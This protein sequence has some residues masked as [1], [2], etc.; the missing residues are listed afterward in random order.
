MSRAF[1]DTAC[2]GISR[3]PEYH[4]YLMQPSDQW[5]AIVASDGIWA[6]RAIGGAV[7]MRRPSFSAVRAHGNAL[8]VRVSWGVEGRQSEEF[9]EGEDCCN[10]TSKKLRLKGPRETVPRRE[11]RDSHHGV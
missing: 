8:G 11:L 1:G 4:K 6:P 3:V 5:Y 10:M 9:I 7:F 2:A